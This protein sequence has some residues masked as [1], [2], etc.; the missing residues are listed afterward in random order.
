MPTL[1]YDQYQTLHSF[2]A[3]SVGEALS[4]NSTQRITLYVIA[5]YALFILIAW[6]LWG[7]RHIIYPFKLLT[8]AFHELSVSTEPLNTIFRFLYSLQEEQ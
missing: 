7:L 6:N 2:Q 5:G 1:V 4:P 8:V 3:R